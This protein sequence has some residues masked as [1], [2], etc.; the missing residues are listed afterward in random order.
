MASCRATAD[1]RAQLSLGDVAYIAPADGHPPRCHVVEAWDEADQAGLARSGGAQ[2]G[3][4]LPRLCDEA[5]VLQH[6][7]AVVVGEADMLELDITRAVQMLLWRRWV[8]HIGLGIQHLG[9]RDL[10]RRR[11]A[12]PG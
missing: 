5:D 8:L 2:N 11:R 4:D 12:K 10:P 7:L 3:D 1:V 9:Y 6:R